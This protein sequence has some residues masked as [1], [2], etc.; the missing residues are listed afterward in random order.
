VIDG[1]I[2]CAITTGA[3]SAWAVATLDAAGSG[4]EP[5]GWLCKVIPLGCDVPAWTSPTYFK[6]D[7]ARPGAFLREPP[8]V[9][10]VMTVISP[11]VE[12]VGRES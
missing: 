4:A 10:C 6:P 7:N 5:T 9:H 1:I 11:H 3:S 8:L 12:A 2:Y